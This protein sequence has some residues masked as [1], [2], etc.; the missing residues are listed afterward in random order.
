MPVC[1]FKEYLATCRSR[2]GAWIEINARVKRMFT[3]SGRSREGAWIE[4]QVE[5]LTN[6]VLQGR[7]REG[8]WIEI[9]ANISVVL[10]W[11]VA[12]VRERGLKFPLKK[13]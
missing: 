5:R 7:S 6:F 10:A 8:A 3:R 12:P 9:Y 4:I 11:Q 13:K 2:E 1:F